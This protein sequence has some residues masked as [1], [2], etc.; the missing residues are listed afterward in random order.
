[1]IRT[2]VRA[3]VVTGLALSVLAFAPAAP[4]QTTISTFIEGDFFSGWNGWGGGYQPDY[5][6]T[7][8]QTFV[9]PKD[10][11]LND[12]TF[13]IRKWDQ[14]NI[15]ISINYQ[16]YVYAWDGQ[17]ATGTA[18]F[19]SAVSSVDA[20]RDYAPHTITTGGTTLVTGQKYVAFLTTTGLPPGHESYGRTTWGMTKNYADGYVDGEFI[21]SNNFNDFD[22]LTTK[23]WAP[24]VNAFDTIFTMNFSP[25]AVPE[26]ATYG[27]IAG[28]LIPGTA[29][30]L[31]RRK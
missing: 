12:F 28:M 22:A 17:K 2:F 21:A 14:F 7:F 10:N 13:Y 19:K 9:A 3:C 30:L 27:L 15:R 4:A 11:V 1:M 24:N 23:P 26:P 20:Y 16:A 31:R 6:P 18:L 29:L 5:T 8:G 25:A